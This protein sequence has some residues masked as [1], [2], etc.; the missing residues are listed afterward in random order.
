MQNPP[1]SHQ[2]KEVHLPE[3]LNS[4]LNSTHRIRTCH[5]KMKN[6]VWKELKIEHLSMRYRLS[7]LKGLL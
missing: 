7:R 1:D 5:I 2:W 3:I 4:Y 6:M